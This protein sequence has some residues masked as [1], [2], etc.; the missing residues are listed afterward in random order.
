VAR[1]S[2]PLAS[3]LPDRIARARADGRTQQ[4]LELTHQLLKQAQNAEHEELLRQVLLE[5]GTQLQQQG[6][7]RDA[8]TVFATALGRGGNVEYRAQLAAHLAD[9][10]DPVRALVAIGPDAEPKLRQ[11]VMGHIADLALRK[12]PGGKSILPAD[13][14]AGFDATIQAFAH[15]EAGRD[16][17]ARAALQAIGLTSPFLEWKLLLRGLLAYYV[18]DDERAMENWQ[19]L[20]VH[21]IPAR[22]AAPLRAGIDPAFRQAQS[23]A[24]QNSLAQTAARLAGPGVS[25]TRLQEVKQALAAKQSLGTAFRKAEAVVPDMRRDRPALVRRLANCFFWAIVDHGQ[26]EDLDRYRRVFAP[27]ANALEMSRLEAL[28]VEQRAMWSEAHK[29]WQDVVRALANA[30][31][32]WPGEIGKRAQALVWEHMGHNAMAQGESADADAP[33][34]LGFQFEKPTPLKPGPVECFVQSIKLAP[35]RLEGYLALFHLHHEEGETAQA[36][37]V[38][39]Q[40]LKRFPNHAATSEALG[41]LMLETQEAGKA[42]DYFEKALSANPLERR[43]RRK[44]ARARQNLGLELTLA[45]KHE[46]ARAEYEAALGMRE[47]PPTPLLCQWA[48]LELKAG[49]PERA[50]ELIER[51]ASPGQRLAARYALVSESVRAKLSVA[52][53]KRI[54]GD[55]TAAL[56]EPPTPAEVLALLEVAAAQRTRQLGAFRGQKTHEKTFL[57]FLDHIPL[58][59]FNESEMERLCGYLQILD[60]RRPWQ[61]CANV[62]DRRFPSNPIFVLHQLDYVLSSRDPQSRPWQLTETLDRAHALVHALPREQQERYLPILRQRQEKVDALR[63]PQLNPFDMFGGM[64][65][66]YEDA[67]DMDDGDDW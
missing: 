25:V 2:K 50:A 5:R 40:L 65:D 16:D 23:P 46:A 53:R 39:E 31:D 18:R 42:R 52:E 58:G 29:S 4:A 66:E 38:G 36:R 6:H 37:K 67:D 63:G 51:A 30:P 34:F 27:L 48:V 13:L 44:L 21:R 41:D 62:A 47:G 19:R 54:A 35:E 22:L 28:A 3:P 26:P 20:D 33:A 32:E 60:A 57:R 11:R 61:Q 15:A 7:A 14:H 17:E 59:E 1:S 43:L 12:G 10:G 64:F 45:G 55:L 56:A 49:R 24:M 9:C 8:A